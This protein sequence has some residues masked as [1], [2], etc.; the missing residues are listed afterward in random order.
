MRA[1]VRVCVCVC[2]CVCARVQVLVFEDAPNGVESAKAAG[3]RVVMVPDR[4]TDREK[5]R[6]ADQVVE[7]L[8]HVDLTQFG[9][10][11]LPAIVSGVETSDK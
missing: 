11:P 1:C 4:R 2:V 3:M 7:S 6:R 5:C 10:P 8:E 9:L